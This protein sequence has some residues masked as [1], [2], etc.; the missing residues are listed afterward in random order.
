MQNKTTGWVAGAILLLIIGG[1]GTTGLPGSGSSSGG[2]GGPAAPA[3]PAA[4]HSG[5][6]QVTS[7]LWQM[8]T[9]DWKV[10]LKD[11]GTVNLPKA[12]GD[13]CDHGSTY[14]YAQKTC[15]G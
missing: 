11:G 1:T 2:S 5:E 10:F 8:Q 12:V 15:K 3:A 6:T 9:G 4:P 14:S 13:K 7:R